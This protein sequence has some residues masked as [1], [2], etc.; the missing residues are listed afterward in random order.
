LKTPPIDQVPYLD[1]REA[2]RRRGNRS[3]EEAELEAVARLETR[4]LEEKKGWAAGD[5]SGD[6]FVE[7]TGEINF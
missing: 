1:T 3:M 4:Q 7:V 5:S 6:V 2:G